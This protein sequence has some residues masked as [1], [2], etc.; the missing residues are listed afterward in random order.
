MP[1]SEHPTAGGEGHTPCQTHSADP[2]P[3]A[4]TKPLPLHFGI[5]LF[6]SFQALD[7]FGALDAL[8]MLSRRYKMHLYVLAATLDPVGTAYDP[9]LYGG[10]PRDGVGSRF[11]QSILPTHTFA[12]APPLDVLLVP[13]GLGTRF[14]RNYEPA[15]AFIRDVFPSL[16]YLITICTGAGL[17]ARAGVLDGHRATTNKLAWDETVALRAGGEVEWV[18]RARWVADGKVWTSSG[19][20][21]GIDCIFA[22]IREVY[23][24]QVGRNVA[25]WMEYVPAMDPDHD[26][27]A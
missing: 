23:G 14:A 12:T 21:A 17:A 6:P 5:I 2:A 13:G 11:G 19:I 20:T 4:P 15:A 1:P 7:A 16:Q 26:P 10:G 25:N 18:R 22:W 8:N 27:F 24:D 3:T 9:A